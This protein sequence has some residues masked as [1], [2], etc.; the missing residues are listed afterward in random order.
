MLR[1]HASVPRLRM[2]I[3][4]RPFDLGQEASLDI[5]MQKQDALSGVEAF[6]LPPVD[7]ESAIATHYSATIVA[8]SHLAFVLN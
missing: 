2:C 3:L 1:S 7:D 5:P 6:L 8:E 4:Q